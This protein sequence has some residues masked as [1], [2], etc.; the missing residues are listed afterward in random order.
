MSQTLSAIF[1]LTDH[2]TLKM[3]K[4]LQST[5][6]A[7][8]VIGQAQKETEKFAQELQREQEAAGKAATGTDKAK[9]AIDQYAKSAKQAQND[10]DSLLKKMASIVSVGALVKQAVTKTWEAANISARQQSQ[11]TTI[12]ALLGDQQAGSDLYNYISEYAKTS[13]LGRED[14]ANATTAFLSY[15]HDMAQIQQLNQMVERLYAKDPSQ[16]ADG[17]VF[18]L[19]EALSGDTMSLKDRFNMGGISG[20]RIREMT[21]TGDVAG[22]IEYLDQVLN[23]YGATQEV[24][25]ANYDNLITQTNIFTSNLLSTIGE[26]AKPVM[27]TFSAV[28]QKLNADMEAGKFQPFFNMMASGMQLI[29]NLIGFVADNASWLAPVL[30]AVVTGLVVYKAVMMA[31]SLVTA[32]MG[33]VSAATTM[34]FV[35]MGAI[36]AG[37][38]LGVGA[39][40]SA[41]GDVEKSSTMSLSA[42]E[43]KAGEGLSNIPLE[44]EI[45]NDDPITVTGEVD[46]EEEN[47]KY[48]LDTAQQKFF[49]QFSYVSK[50]PQ[51]NIYGQTIEKTVDLNEVTEYLGDALAEMSA[52]QPEGS[53]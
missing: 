35:Q 14:L 4:I 18:A 39:L 50:S 25:E 41:F 53:Y 45:V 38:T 6:S 1:E 22:T 34:N 3:Q 10:T 27:E 44:A 12:G 26:Q 28:I 43:Q 52:V 5:E 7:Q 33:L 32:I 8:N 29:G 19:K 24:V 13:A 17:A 47:L 30:S 16:G 40:A 15:T 2:Y 11:E 36:I 23:K 31:A 37:V 21:D 48:L 20:A 42:L 9:Q 51:V 49:A 46:I